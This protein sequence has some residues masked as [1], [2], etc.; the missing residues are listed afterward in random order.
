MQQERRLS[1]NTC[2]TPY[3]ALKVPTGR[4]GQALTLLKT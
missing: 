3:V 1:Q 2:V 4:R